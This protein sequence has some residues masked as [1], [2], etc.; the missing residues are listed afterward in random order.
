MQCHATVYYLI[1][2]MD[3]NTC[4]RMLQDVCRMQGTGDLHD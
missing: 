1:F 3:I 4:L 2:L